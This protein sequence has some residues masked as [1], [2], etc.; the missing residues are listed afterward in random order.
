MIEA[1]IYSDASVK[2]K[3]CGIA[4]AIL[5]N[6]GNLIKTIARRI[7][8]L[9]KDNTA[10]EG[11]AIIQGI[12]AARKMGFKNIRVYS[13]SKSLIQV[14]NSGR[15]S[16]PATKGFLQIIGYLRK[17]LTISFKWVRGHAGKKW[18]VLCDRLAKNAEYQFH[19]FLEDVFMIGY[20]RWMEGI[21]KIRHVV[22]NVSYF[23]TKNTI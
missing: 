16:K 2:G 1:I 11:R 17:K 15:A 7:I 13:D 19:G 9:T 12:K 6:N 3:Y 4:V 23:A 10:A 5:D 20:K 22:C 18:N 14:V 21:C 8:G